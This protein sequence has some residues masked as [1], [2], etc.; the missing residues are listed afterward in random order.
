MAAE[1]AAAHSS[2]DG[3]PL[4]LERDP[5]CGGAAGVVQVQTQDRVQ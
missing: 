4:S 3:P 1:E 5:G 2:D